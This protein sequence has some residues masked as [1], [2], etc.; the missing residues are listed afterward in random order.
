MRHTSLNPHMKMIIDIEMLFQ[1]VLGW[2]RKNI[3]TIFKAAFL[4]SF[5]SFLRISNL[6]PHSIEMFDHMRQFSS[7]DVIF[8]PPCAH[9][10]VKLS[11][12]I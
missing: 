8:A 10:I 2:D 11:K 6:V 1:L 5:F 7:A 9:L 12:P 4:T 3:G